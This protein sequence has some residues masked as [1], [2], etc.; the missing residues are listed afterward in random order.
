MLLDD[1]CFRIE[2]QST[3]A[4]IESGRGGGLPVQG[5]TNDRSG[6]KQGFVKTSISQGMTE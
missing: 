5:P 3:L 6:S 1:P 2:T 4:G